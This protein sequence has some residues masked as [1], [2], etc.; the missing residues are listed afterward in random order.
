MNKKYIVRS[1]AAAVAL[2]VMSQGAL[3]KG[4]D[5]GS[6]PARASIEG[7]YR[8]TIQPYNCAT[9]QPAPVAPF[10]SILSFGRGGTLQEAPS[11]ARFAPGQRVPG[12]GYWER[13][14]PS[15]Y[16]SVFEA[17][18]VFD[19]ADYKRGLQRIEQFIVQVDADH[20][21]SEALVLFLDTNGTVLQTGCMRAK[22]ERMK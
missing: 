13:T 3:A 18:I 12:L 9:G 17:F 1:A 7:T 4:P 14:G 5:S 8:T 15:D 6:S 20:W 21:E 2:V 22:G 16:N 10:K 19:S 11:N